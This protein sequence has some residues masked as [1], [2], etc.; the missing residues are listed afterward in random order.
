MRLTGS[1]PVKLDRVNSIKI[2]PNGEY[3]VAASADIQRFNSSGGLI[4]KYDVPSHDNLI[5]LSL[6]PDGRS[7]WAADNCNSNVWKF[8]VESGKAVS[9]FNAVIVPGSTRCILAK[10]EPEQIDQHHV[11]KV[12]MKLNLALQNKAMN[13][14]KIIVSLRKSNIGFPIVGISKATLDEFGFDVTTCCDNDSRAVFVYLKLCAGTEGGG[15]AGIGVSLFS[16]ECTSKSFSGYNIEIAGFWEAG[17]GISI[18][19]ENPLEILNAIQSGNIG[20]IASA[21]VSNANGLEVIFG[22]DMVLKKGG[23]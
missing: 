4:L 11:T 22:E 9:T 18:G 7:F 3:V 8:D 15:S 19:I 21:F 12:S 23:L 10:N 2:F 14:E 17:G 16:P 5:S 6:D 1:Q 20:E 13:G